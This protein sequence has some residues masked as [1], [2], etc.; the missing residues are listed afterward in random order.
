MAAQYEKRV[1]TMNAWGQKQGYP[2]FC[3]VV[4][5]INKTG[6][7]N[8][9]WEKDRVPTCTSRILEGRSGTQGNNNKTGLQA[10]NR[11]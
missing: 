7:P 9:G 5:Q 8:E 2:P 4:T 11:K 3:E 10:L 6:T 1:L